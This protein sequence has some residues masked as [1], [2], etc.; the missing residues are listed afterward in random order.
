MFETFSVKDKTAVL[1]ELDELKQVR[2][3]MMEEVTE[4]TSQLEKEKSKNHSLKSE[5]DKMKV[6]LLSSS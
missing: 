1:L 6:N 2:D 3:E 5:I 4:L